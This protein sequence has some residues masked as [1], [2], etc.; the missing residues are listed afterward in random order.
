MTR[1]ASGRSHH[2]QDMR[3]EGGSLTTA[4]TLIVGFGNVLLSDD[5]FGV[6]VMHRL[7][8]SKLPP[9]IDTMDVG[10][11]GMHFVLRLLEGFEVLIVVDAIQ[12]G[13]PPGTL[14]VFTP[15]AGDLAMQ[16]GECV[17][18]HG[19]EPASSMKLAKALGLLP[20]K[21]TV[22]GC[23]PESCHV[24]MSLTVAVN[25]AVDH[26]VEHIRAMVLTDTGRAAGEIRPGTPS[27]PC[28]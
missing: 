5:G 21:V 11:G 24:G 6:E 3:A 23:E 14:Y 1:A 18:P 28:L 10:I 17:D 12:R 7:A 26:A 27:L 25:A 4:K 13:Q 22:V 19:A 16:T 20:E 8:A 9:H 15:G 2:W